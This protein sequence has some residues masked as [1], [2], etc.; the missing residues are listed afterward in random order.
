[1]Q[2]ESP[3][4]ASPVESRINALRG[5]GR[6]LPE[7]ARSFMEARFNAD[8]SGV[9]VHTDG[10]AVDLARTVSAQAFTVGRDIVF[11][12]GHYVPESESGKRLLA[13]ELAHVVQQTGTSP[14]HGED[15]LRTDGAGAA[16]QTRGM[17]QRTLTVQNPAN[18]IPNPTGTG[19]VQ[20]NATTIQNYLQ[21]ICNAGNVTVNPGSGVV[22]IGTNAFCT[23]RNRTFLGIPI[24]FTETTDAAQSATP[25]GCT[26]VCDMIASTHA[27]N[28]VVDDGA[29]PHTDF[30][31]RD[32]ANGITPGGTGGTVTA[33][34]PNSP[35]LWGAGTASGAAQNIDPWLV[36]GH[37]LCGHAW[38]G[39]SG[40]HGPDVAQARGRGGHQ[41][42]VA[43][44]NQLR[45]EHG[46]DLRGTYKDPN[47]GESFWRDRT[48]PAAVNWSS[49]RTVCEQWRAE[50]NL[51]HGTAYT[52]MDRIP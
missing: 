40:S 47:C 29:W 10:G 28:I 20:S 26:C 11:D 30:D 25:A 19:V 3:E 22:S 13:H 2:G 31:D 18:N 52:I 44:E 35:K 50:Y 24:P 36:L 46:I 38:L 7:T 12:A 51:A 27:W 42:T 6:S 5:N 34:S 41:A 32:A 21:T 8:F 1:V 49:Y 15:A 14:R 33:P 23:R 45:A 48:A 17:V 37:E 43:R 39:N 9:R 4:V 16:L